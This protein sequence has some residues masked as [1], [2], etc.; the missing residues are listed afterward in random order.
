MGDYRATIRTVREGATDPGGFVVE[1]HRTPRA[2]IDVDLWSG[3]HLLHL[4]IASCLFND[5]L[6]EAPDRGILV[7][8]LAVTAN[9]DFDQNGSSGIRYA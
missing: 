9:G 5:I 8:H 3:G 1:H 7:D 2:A 6:R 4:A